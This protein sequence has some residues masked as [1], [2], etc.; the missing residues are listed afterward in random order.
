M[1]LYRHS[2]QSEDDFWCAR[3]FLS[4]AHEDLADAL[5]RSISKEMK[6]TDT[7]LKG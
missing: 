7:W 4:T 3:N 6:L 1:T 5:Y 2:C